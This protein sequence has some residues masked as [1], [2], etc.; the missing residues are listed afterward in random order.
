M[1]K[2]DLIEVVATRTRRPQAETAKIANELLA[3][4]G[5][6]LS[7]GREIQIRRFGAFRIRRRGSREMRNPRTGESYRVPAKIVPVF[8]ASRALTALVG[9]VDEAGTAGEERPS[10]GRD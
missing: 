1:N 5:R 10:A 8:R 4:V 9:S 7:E 6:A 3:A 2:A